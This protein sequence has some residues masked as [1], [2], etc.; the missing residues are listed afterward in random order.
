MAISFT[1]G[2][3]AESTSGTVTPAI[4]GSSDSST[5]LLLICC[6]RQTVAY[7]SM[8]GNWT[9]IVSADYS[10]V[11]SM[12]IAWAPGTE[13]TDPALVA[14][15]SGNPAVAQVIRVSG[16]DTTSPIGN[17]GSQ[18]VSTA[19]DTTTIGPIPMPASLVSSNGAILDVGFRR[20]TG[21]SPAT[22]VSIGSASTG[23]TWDSVSF[24]SS[25]SGSDG[26]GCT[27]GGIYTSAPTLSDETFTN[28][29]G[30]AL[31]A[32]YG[33]S[34]ELKAATGGGG[35]TDQPAVKRFGGVPFMACNRGVW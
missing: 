29:G 1:Y 33:Q 21:D 27:C 15:R 32:R 3:W 24:M 17:T 7:T 19:T 14:D 13:T 12:Y 23:I 2:T 28:G 5:I 25:I 22:S 6:T 8:G 16:V 20:M 10:T 11:G 9:D 31:N 26:L 34:V 35:G 18:F 30:S 4:P